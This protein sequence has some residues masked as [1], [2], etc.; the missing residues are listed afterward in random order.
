[1][2]G[3]GKKM[4]F[5]R[6][7]PT[8]TWGGRCGGRCGH[9][10]ISCPSYLPNTRG[11]RQLVVMPAGT[12][13]RYW[14]VRVAA[15]TAQIN[16]ASWVDLAAPVLFPV[17]TV[18]A[19]AIYAF[20]RGQPPA[21]VPWLVLTLLGAGW[22][23]GTLWRTRGRAF[24]RRDARILLESQLHLDARLTAATAGV[25]PWP[26][27]APV[28]TLLRWR[29]RAAAGW[30]ALAAALVAIASVAPVPR[31][32][33]VAPVEKPPSLAQTE[34]MLDAL[35]Q[36][37]LVEPHALE[38]AESRTQEL[39]RRPVD[40]QY[41]HSALEAADTLRDETSA[42]VSALSRNLDAAANALQSAD[43]NGALDDSAGRLAA[44]LAGLREGPMPVNPQLLAQLPSHWAGLAGLSAAQRQQLARQLADAS[45]RARGIAGAAGAGVRV[46]QADPSKKIDPREGNGTGG[47]G[48]TGGGEKSA[49]LTFSSNRSDAA[50]GTNQALNPA[51]LSRLALG[52]R[53]GTTSG[54]PD[55]D[56]KHT[57]DVVA[58]GAFAAPAKGGDAVWI[59]HLTPT[60]R[61]ALKD[62]FK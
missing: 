62:L 54:A 47:P 39:S 15:L 44:S 1:M 48:G 31:G 45:R 9:V 38:E 60:E 42:A 22:L 24:S 8:P 7:H 30:F 36:A 49:P 21:W 13:R 3:S 19:I 32:T 27:V 5:E 37:N 14:E 26:P 29:L 61:A 12:A 23:V 10:H 43:A 34:A 50:D 4:K 56:S 18:A 2:T 59:D 17:A 53:L 16:L 55:A 11:N 57:L 41:A 52:D 20:R 6:R 33:S 58:A 25:V 46:A 40:E 28:P 35:A 51:D